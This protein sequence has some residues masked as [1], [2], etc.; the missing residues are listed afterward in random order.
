MRL[1]KILAAT[2][3]AGMFLPLLTV[4]HAQS[5][6]GRDVTMILSPR[7]TTVAAGD[8]VQVDLFIN[9]PTKKSLTSVETLL[10]YDKTALKGVSVAYPQDTPFEMNLL[11]TGESEFDATTGQVRLSRA[12]LKDT[13]LLAD[14]KYSYATLTFEV[15][16]N[17]S[18]ALID[19]IKTQGGL[20]RVTA[21]ATVEG[22]STNVMN[23]DA[24]T[25]VT[26]TISGTHSSAATTSTGT[27]VTDIFTSSNTNTNT[28]TTNT[29]LNLNTNSV[30]PVSTT[31]NL[32]TNFATL[33]NTNTNGFSTV[34]NT[35]LNLNTNVSTTVVQTLDS[36][37]DVAIKKDGKKITLYWS[38]DD[39]AQGTYIYYGT[40][41]DSFKTRKQVAYPDSSF[42][43]SSMAAKGTYYFVLTHTDASGHESAYTPMFVVDGVKNGIYYENDSYL[44]KII[45]RGTLGATT[46]MTM[47][48]SENARAS[49]AKVPTMPAN[50]PAEMVLLLLLTSL[51][52]AAFLSTRRHTLLS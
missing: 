15:T 37:R 4:A 24:L 16:G 42:T 12:T 2:L 31:T 5:A 28:V 18:S 21:N 48:I 8:Q 35:N 1:T 39:M 36:P 19:F 27:T 49:L 6:S 22:I 10:S 32:N 52:G 29:N 34:T 46:V 7:Q 25:P 14:T 51:G 50:G 23:V 44:T 38:N 40:S 11:S 20:E 9:N 43:F 26:L 3:V 33:S 45:D 17:A 13:S 47:G 41:P 30:I